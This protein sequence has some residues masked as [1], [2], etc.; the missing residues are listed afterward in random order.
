M[1]RCL[2]AAQRP[3]L[4]MTVLL[5]VTSCAPRPT[6]PIVPNQGTAA[7]VDSGAAPPP[8]ASPTATSDADIT[9]DTTTPTGPFDRRL[10]GTNI[11]AWLHQPSQREAFSD[12]ALLAHTAGSGATLLRFP[13]GSWS[14]YYDW[15]GCETA[16]AERGSADG[17]YW[18]W[19]ARP[20]DF[21]NAIRRTSLPAIWAVSLEGT[22]QSA[23]ALVAFFNGDVNDSRPIGV[24]RNGRDWKTVGEW[25]RLRSEHGNPAPQK[26]LLWEIGNEVYGAK[27]STAGQECSEYGWEEVWTC[28]GDAYVRGDAA[29]DGFVAFRQEMRRI[30]P[31]ILVGA[32]GVGRQSDWNDWG[33][34]VIAG[35][36]EVMD[37]YSIHNYG[38]G[39][40]E[41]DVTRVLAQPQVMW[42]DVMSDVNAAFDRH[43]GGR[44]V[45]VAVTEYNLFAFRELDT[46]QLMARAANALFIADTI[47]QLA[48]HGFAIANQWNL[49]NGADPGGTPD[50][51]GM[52][53]G[54]DYR[55]APQYY[56]FPL[57]SRFGSQMLPVSS[58]F[59]PSRALSVYAG[60]ADD[61]TITL[62]A[63]NK[64]DQPVEATIQLDGAPSMMSGTADVLQAASLGA[65]SVTL[66]GVSEPAPDLS[67]APGTPLTNIATPLE[68]AFQPYSVTLLRL[69]AAQP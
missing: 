14:N 24:D 50:V 47:G 49:A 60:R 23:A 45:P 57:W 4:I 9:V 3:L 51:Y 18:T 28:D 19:A 10:L 33:N 17:C 55:R 41:S 43:A 48:Q 54:D 68:Y 66:N 69:G 42:Q 2:S 16:N 64:T 31:E 30:D 39:E 25:A 11:P 40:K 56:A 21:A 61:G 58:R 36:G 53:V 35:A 38:F 26:I 52:L 8:T 15:L 27:R 44:R 62:M 22:A 46:N 32:V 34:K 59:D 67:D 6:A 12:Q 7:P 5:V 13:G 63:I 65:T 37:F 20:T 29:H 1:N